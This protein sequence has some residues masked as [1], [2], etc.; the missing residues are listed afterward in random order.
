MIR[1]IEFNDIDS[2]VKIHLATF[3]GFF[4]SFLGARFLSLYYSGIYKDSNGIGYVFVEDGKV[5]GFVA[6]TADPRGFYSKLLRRD[7]LRFALASVRAVLKKPSSFMRIARAVLYP[8][9]N[10]SG[11]HI[12]GLYSLGVIPEK[13][14][15]G[16]GQKLVLSFLYDAKKRGCKLVTLTTDR[17]NN[18]NVNLFYCKMGFKIQQQYSTSEKRHMNSYVTFID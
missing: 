4:L 11:D 13:Q 5:C 6:G 18:D 10:L 14:G 8:S 12:A 1:P 16:I 17:Y 7:W 2:I 15:A 3:K 9:Q